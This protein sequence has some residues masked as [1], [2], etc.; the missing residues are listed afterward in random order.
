M[1]RR[2]ELPKKFTKEERECYQWLY[3]SDVMGW[4]VDLVDKTVRWIDRKGKTRTSKS[5]VVFARLKG[6]K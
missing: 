2:N 5:L 1:D 4:V 3:D 6:M